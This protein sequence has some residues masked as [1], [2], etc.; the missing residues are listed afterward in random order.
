MYFSI[1]CSE[2][3]NARD[4]QGGQE[5][6]CQTQSLGTDSRAGKVTFRG[7]ETVFQINIIGR[8]QITAGKVQKPSPGSQR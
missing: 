8:I 5:G 3:A 2:P 1:P 4:R 7:E 6:M